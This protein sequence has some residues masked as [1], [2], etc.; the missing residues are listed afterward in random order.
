[1]R[2][3]YDVFPTTGPVLFGLLET[4]PLVRTYFAHIGPSFLQA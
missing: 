4:G 1:M 3:S 2:V